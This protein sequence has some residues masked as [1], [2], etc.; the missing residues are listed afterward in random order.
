MQKKITVF[1]TSAIVM[2]VSMIQASLTTILLQKEAYAQIEF[3]QANS[4]KSETTQIV[5]VKCS[6][7]GAITCNVSQESNGGSPITHEPI[8][9]NE[10]KATR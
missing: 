2:M 9:T 5:D 3:T 6:G 4:I 1:G 7:V 8:T 10:Y